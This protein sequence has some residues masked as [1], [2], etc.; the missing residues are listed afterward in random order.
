MKRFLITL[1][2]FAGIFCH[3]QTQADMYSFKV[4]YPQGTVT[5][6]DWINVTYFLEAL[7]YSVK[8]VE[9]V[10]GLQLESINRTKRVLNNGFDLVTTTCIYT[11]TAFGEIT[12][13]K[14]DASVNGKP[15]SSN[16]IVL[17]VQPNPKYGQEWETAKAFLESRGIKADHLVVRY[18]S[19]ALAAFSDNQAKA[20][21]V[22]ARKDYAPFLDNPVL[23]YG[24]GNSIWDGNN[25]SSENTVRHI[26][27]QYNTQLQ[28]VKNKGEV[29]HSLPS[30]LFIGRPESVKP[31]LGDVS[32]G[33]SYPYN[34]F[35]PK[36]Q[37]NDR[38]ST[39]LVG[40]GPVALAHVL[41]C[42]KYPDKPVG[43]GYLNLVSGKQ[44]VVQ[45]K[46]APFSWDGSKSGIAALMLCSAASVR[47][48]ISPTGTESSISDFKGAL[49]NNWGY[50][51]KCNYMVNQPDMSMLEALYSDLGSGRPVIAGDG[52][53]IFVIDGYDG[54]FLHLN[55]GWEGYCN[56]YYKAIVVQSDKRHQLPFSE[57]L[58]GIRPMKQEDTFEVSVKVSKPG[59][60]NKELEKEL[61]KLK[62]TRKIEDIT[63]LKLTGKLNGIDVA[64]LRRLLGGDPNAKP[65]EQGSLMDLDMA[66][67]ALTHGGCYV[68]RDASKMVFSGTVMNGGSPMAYRYDMARITPQEWS[69]MQALGL[70]QG[71]TW[72]VQ[73]APAGG[74]IVN[75][76]EEIDTIGP[77][78]FAD[79]QN[80]RNIVLPKTAKEIMNSA[81]SGCHAIQSVT[82]I[83]RKVASDAFDNSSLEGRVY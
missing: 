44:M 61:T 70:S 21:A 35:F 25:S 41:S 28:L 71:A 46:D 29:Y 43:K 1:M 26:L 74:F 55:M 17:N 23:A 7:N 10:N 15:V 73:P 13:P 39:C 69:Q 50:S 30:S 6:G 82:G 79:C 77:Y 72:L 64:F 16:P 75:W 14:L 78:M 54:D 33:Q 81:F 36:S 56:G 4:M 47:A 68:T 27:T 53:H 32:Y 57:L 59:T 5:Q 3:A 45:M 31:I 40:C 42:Y 22:I 34:A 24:I 38:D 49:I 63:S 80:L 8:D 62:E 67:V 83:P 20:Y 51:P 19:D 52:A 60:L 2:L 12:L 11:V 66:D 65:E 76:Y 9:Q 58:S 37:Y 18:T 48:K